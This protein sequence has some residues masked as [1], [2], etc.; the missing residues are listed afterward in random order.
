M[1]E[2]LTYTITEAAKLL[3][4][5]RNAAYN[6]ARIGALPTIKI[7]HR[8]LIPKTALERLLAATGP[9]G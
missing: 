5:G 7:G 8:I 9:G 2:R 6:A 3:G 1:N 4:I